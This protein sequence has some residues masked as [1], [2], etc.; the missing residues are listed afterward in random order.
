MLSN[1]FAKRFV[2]LLFE[3]II[4]RM[5]VDFFVFSLAKERRRRGSRFLV[6]ALS[7]FVPSF[8]EKETFDKG[9]D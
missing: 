1:K 8:Y 6:F 5:I 3:L 2:C 4:G 7:L 9:D